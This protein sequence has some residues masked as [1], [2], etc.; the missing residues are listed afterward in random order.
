V[1][2]PSESAERVR[3]RKA[4]SQ[5]AGGASGSPGRVAPS[6]TS[7]SA[8]WQPPLPASPTIPPPPLNGTA[9]HLGSACGTVSP[10][11]ARS[12]GPITRKALAAVILP[13]TIRDLDAPDVQPTGAGTAVALPT[14]AVR[15]RSTPISTTRTS[16][17]RSRSRIPLLWPTKRPAPGW[18]VRLSRP[19]AFAFP[20]PPPRT[21]LPRIVLRSAY[22]QGSTS[23]SVS[24][25]YRH[26]TRCRYI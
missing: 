7:S 22:A 15:P 20:P 13:R 4:D 24:S 9:L 2:W 21:D 12:P 17:I 25:R 19:A 8:S 10:A 23:R 11:A 18:P 1:R 5:R 14:V 3:C 16:T 26:H 6:Q